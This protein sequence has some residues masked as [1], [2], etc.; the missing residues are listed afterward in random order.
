[1]SLY[2]KRENCR[3]ITCRVLTSVNFEVPLFIDINNGELLFKL[4]IGDKIGDVFEN[5]DN[6]VDCIR[7]R[8]YDVIVDWLQDVSIKPIYKISEE[9]ESTSS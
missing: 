1:V 5:I 9:I 8:L 4:S 6:L 3:V 2:G 7:D